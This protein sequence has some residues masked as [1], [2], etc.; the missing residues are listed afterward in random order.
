MLQQSLAGGAQQQAS[1][2]ATTTGTDNNHI[3]I[4]AGLGQCADGRAGNDLLV[5]FQIRMRFLQRLDTHLKIVLVGLHDGIL[6]IHALQ[7]RHS[8]NHVQFRTPAR[9]EVGGNVQRLQTPLG[10]VGAYGHLGNRVVQ[11]HQVAV[12]IGVRHHYNRAVGVCRQRR[13][14]GAQQ[15]LGQTALATVADDDQIV[16]TRQFDEHRCRISGNNQRGRFDALLVCDGLGLGQNLLSIGMCGV[17]VPHR[18]VSGIERNGGIARQGICADN[19]QRQPRVLCIIRGP[20]CCLVTGMRPVHADE[21]GLVVNH[22]D[23]LEG[24]RG[25]NTAYLQQYPA[26]L[27]LTGILRSKRYSCI[28]KKAHPKGRALIRIRLPHNSCHITRRMEYPAPPNTETPLTA[29]PC[30]GFI[31]FITCPLPM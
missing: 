21:N 6:A 16:V 12:I 25:T 3:V 22:D 17:I 20:P 7:V 29:V 19:L 10:F 1:E 26:T 23:L 4:V 18:R 15:T 28:R 8:G 2:A 13:G 27:G 9:G 5:D 30:T 31:A 11:V 24:I 14:R